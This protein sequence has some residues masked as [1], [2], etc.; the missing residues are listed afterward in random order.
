MVRSRVVHL[1]YLK[2]QLQTQK[3][4][5]FEPV[6]QEMNNLVNQLD[7]QADAIYIEVAV[8]NFFY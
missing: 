2:E 8:D 6:R 1:R 4:L 7:I 3:Q 5:V